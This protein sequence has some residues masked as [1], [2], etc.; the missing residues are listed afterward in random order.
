MYIPDILW[1]GLAVMAGLIGWKFYGRQILTALDQ[2]DQRRIDADRQMVADMKN[3]LAHFRRSLEAINDTV[4]PV[5]LI[6]MD[7][8]SE[9]SPIWDET[10]FETVQAAEEARWRH[11]IT[12]ARTFYQGLDEDFGLRVAGPAP[13]TARDG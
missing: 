6:R 5:M 13:K 4:P 8:A 1:I 11:V 2:F 9:R 12:Q 7:G 10:V 3:P